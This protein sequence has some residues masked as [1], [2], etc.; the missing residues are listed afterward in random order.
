MAPAKK[1]VKRKNKKSDDKVTKDVTV[2]G[3]T[4]KME[5]D[6]SVASVIEDEAPELLK[7]DNL[8]LTDEE[9]FYDVNNGGRQ[10]SPRS[11]ELYSESGDEKVSASTETIGHQPVNEYIPM[12]TENTN[13][14]VS[15]KL[16]TITTCHS[17]ASSEGDFDDFQEARIIKKSREELLND[18]RALLDIPKDD[19]NNLNYEELVGRTRKEAEGLVQKCALSQENEVIHPDLDIIKRQL[20]EMRKI[21]KKDGKL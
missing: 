19:G 16:S 20:V 11:R 8:S 6:G 12:P 2:D 14:K 17:G 7:N 3:A 5:T 21:H 4:K 9:I 18:I 10:D 15:S 1:G 13:T